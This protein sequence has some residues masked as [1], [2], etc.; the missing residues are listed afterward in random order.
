MGKV[1]I[2]ILT[3]RPKVVAGY[4]TNQFVYPETTVTKNTERSYIVISCEGRDTLV[5]PSFMVLT[6]RAF[7]T[8]NR[9]AEEEPA[10]AD[11]IYNLYVNVTHV[12][13]KAV[14]KFIVE[15]TIEDVCKLITTAFHTNKGETSTDLDT[16]MMSYIKNH[17]SFVLNPEQNGKSTAKVHMAVYVGLL[18]RIL[19]PIINM[20]FAK[21]S[22]LTIPSGLN[23]LHKIVDAGF[24]MNEDMK[25]NAVDFVY[26]QFAERTT[27]ETILGSVEQT[28]KEYMIFVFPML[29][30]P[31]VESNPYNAVE[32]M[33][34]LVADALK[35]RY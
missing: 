25:N 11:S 16:R 13:S 26:K 23:E 7:S 10:V 14:D 33:K 29:L 22:Y 24:S 3:E 21:Y 31:S 20:L 15:K 9:F 5:I 32:T 1:C 12:L 27:D 28:F 34:G 4:V 17:Y 30:I 8:I 19:L 2:R 18:A 6:H 35:N